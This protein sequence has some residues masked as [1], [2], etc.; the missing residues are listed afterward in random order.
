MLIETLK[1]THNLKNT[2]L[3]QPSYF[4]AKEAEL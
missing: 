3:V 4:T 1:M 2:D